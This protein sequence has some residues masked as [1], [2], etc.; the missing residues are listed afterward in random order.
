MRFMPGLNLSSKTEQDHGVHQAE[1]RQRRRQHLTVRYGEPFD[2]TAEIY[3]ICQP[4]A[5]KVAAEPWPQTYR[6][7]VDDLA[8]AV[9][10]L[11]IVV[12][13]LVATAD[14]RRK[15]GDLDAADRGRAVAVLKE[16]TERPQVPAISDGMLS[17]GLWVQELTAL[18]G[19]LTG[20]LS[21]LLSRAA[22]PGTRRGLLSVSEQLVEGLRL[23]D[24]AAVALERHLQRAEVMRSSRPARRP[25]PPDKLRA[26]LEKL[27]VRP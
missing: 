24:R 17:S 22:A 1:Q 5:E 9:G 15:T 7:D 14:A 16:L 21:D 2:L 8:E 11:V 19:P 3:D 27:G 26:E 25:A 20:K 18:A 23:V 6:A 10:S 13:D 12:S 4:L